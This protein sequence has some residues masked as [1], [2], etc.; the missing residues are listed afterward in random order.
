MDTL[1][2]FFQAAAPLMAG[3]LSGMMFKTFVYPMVLARL[4]S[5]A[6]LVNS[7]GNRLMGLLFV[8]VPLGLA[9]LCHSS[10]AEKTLAWLQAHPGLLSPVQPTPFLLQVTFHAAAFYCAFL[11]AA[12]PDP[13]PR[14]QVRPE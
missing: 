10:N 11:L 7:R 13:S 9:V 6:G 1:L 2:P 12:F 5:L 3:A 4:G 8:A 14:G